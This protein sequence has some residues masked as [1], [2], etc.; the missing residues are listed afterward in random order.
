M[1]SGKLWDAQTPASQP[2]DGAQGL[3]YA[4]KLDVSPNSIRIH[5]CVYNMCRVAVYRSRGLIAVRAA[6]AGLM[7]PDFGIVP[8]RQT[9]CERR[10]SAHRFAMPISVRLDASAMR[11]MSRCA[12]SFTAAPYEPRGRSPEAHALYTLYY[13]TLASTVSYRTADPRGF[14]DSGWKGSA[15]CMGNE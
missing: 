12:R 11:V 5:M 1:A 8:I 7:A 6:H 14:S 13:R 10:Q 15:K 3:R 2:H 4:L 9:E